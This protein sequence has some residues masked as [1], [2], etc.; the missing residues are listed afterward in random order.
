MVDDDPRCPLCGGLFTPDQVRAANPSA[1]CTFCNASVLLRRPPSEPEDA[2]PALP[3][4]FTVTE[5]AAESALAPVAITPY[6]EPGREIVQHDGLLIEWRVDNKAVRRVGPIATAATLTAGAAIIGLGLAFT[7]PGAVVCGLMP[8]LCGVFGWIFTRH[9]W[10]PERALLANTEGI[11]FLRRKLL[12]GWKPAH[13]PAAEI[14]QLYVVDSQDPDKAVYPAYARFELRAKDRAGRSHVL[15]MVETPEQAWWLESRLEQHLGLIDRP[16][17][18]ELE[19][20]R[21]A[22]PK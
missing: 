14:A 20:P 22:M 12:G 15:V 4:G 7:E 2:P 10:R 11:Q 17:P 1:T 3:V 16:V 19:R 9:W 21:K 13:L 18:G 8:V 6:R 5:L